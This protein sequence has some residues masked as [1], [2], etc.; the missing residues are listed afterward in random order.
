MEFVE[1]QNPLAWASG[2]A[3]I[4]FACAILA[5]VF[6]AI[7]G[8]AKILLRVTVVCLGVFLGGLASAAIFGIIATTGD[9]PAVADQER[10]VAEQIGETYGLNVSVED[11]NYPSKRP[12]SPHAYG[13]ALATGQGSDVFHVRLLWDGERM[14]LEVGDPVNEAERVG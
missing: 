5:L 9:G 2:V 11:L 14:L 12:D 13:S 10:V 1:L 7:F 8:I 3:T 6:F 4:L